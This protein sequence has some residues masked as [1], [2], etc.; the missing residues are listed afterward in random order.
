MPLILGTNSIK[1]TGY[2]VDNSCMFN[3]GDSPSLTLTPGSNSA[4][5]TALTISFWFKRGVLAAGGSDIY[6]IFHTTTTNSGY[7]YLA[8][9]SS[10]QI[11]F[12]IQNNDYTQS[13]TTGFKERK[14]TNRVFRDPSAWY[15]CVIEVDT[16]ESTA[17]DRLKIWINGVRE[18]SWSHETNNTNQNQS[19]PVHVG[20]T[21]HEFNVGRQGN[22]T[23][24]WDGY[25]AEFFYIDGTGYGASSFGE[26][27]EDSP[28]IWKPKDC[29][30]DLTFGTNGFYLDFEDSAN[31][32]NDANGGTDFSENNIAATDQ[33]TDTPTNNF[34]TL[35]P[36]HYAHTTDADDMPLSEGN[37]KANS[38]QGGS[39]YPYVHS[40]LAAAAGKWYAEFKVVSASASMIGIADGVSG[41]YLGDRA[42]DEAYFADGNV[43]T[44]NTSWGDALSDDDILMV[45][46]DLDNS[47]IYF[48]INGTWQN[49]GDPTSGATGTGA[50]SIAASTTGWWHFAV[51][52]SSSGT[53]TTE[54][55]FGNPAYANSSSAS[56][57]NGYGD[58]EYAPPSGYLALCTKNLGSDG[59]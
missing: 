24:Y 48:G 21:S 16:T 9:N 28:T 49:S 42:N 51:G 23:Y 8:I 55:N 1:D 19:L 13:P 35:N 38:S 25:L 14:I 4:S 15:H 7:I 53:P 3:R 37:T 33:A 10:Q 36:L 6:S 34:A 56:D 52:D 31:L 22:G 18:S 11:D 57:A 45:A 59:G 27:D 20:S 50:S 39:P 30:G 12:A 47:K 58:F 41:T 29:S 46:V 44:G 43:Y 32:G 54:C 40:T 2:D 5:R 17:T 26:Y